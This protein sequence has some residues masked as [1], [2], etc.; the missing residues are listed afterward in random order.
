M[1]ENKL[2]YLPYIPFGAR[3]ETIMTR[4]GSGKATACASAEEIKVRT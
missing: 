2:I 4:D 3:Q 1:H